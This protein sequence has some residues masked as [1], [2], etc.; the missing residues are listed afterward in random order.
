VGSLNI[1]SDFHHRLL[2]LPSLDTLKAPTN[3]SENA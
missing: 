1:H 2:M 3:N